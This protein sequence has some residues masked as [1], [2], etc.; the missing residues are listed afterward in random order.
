MKLITILLALSTFTS[1]YAATYRALCTGN[2][3]R[4]AVVMQS[5]KD[6]LYVRYSNAMGSQDFPLYEGTVTRAT[7]SWLKEADKDLASLDKEVMV[8]WAM[9]QCTFN[10]KVPW[11]MQC[12]GEARFEL[13]ENSS[14]KSYTFATSIVNEA[15]LTS[16]F[17][18]Y[19]I[20]WGIDSEDFHHHI[21]MPFDPRHCQASYV[22]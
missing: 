22:P 9:E 10:Q 8:S 11:L 17:E 20:R 12:G 5:Y 18:I 13:P 16:N 4:I 6:R 21:A 7:F 14:L 3:G 15:S 19:K 1:A 2:N